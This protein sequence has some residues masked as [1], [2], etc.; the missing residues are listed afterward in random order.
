[1]INRIA[2][3]SIYVDDQQRALEFWQNLGFE[4]RKD[5]ENN[6]H[7]W[8]EVAAPG[9][10]TSLS[11]YP[12]KL[13]DGKR[14]SFPIVFLCDNIDYLWKEMREKGVEFKQEPTRINSENFAVFLDE[15]GNE[16]VLEEAK[17]QKS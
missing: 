8:L 9:S 11:L 4:V 5:D 6:G 16:F 10:E 1:M 7:R 2:S 17:R 15:D 3:V 12:K 13:A 14:K